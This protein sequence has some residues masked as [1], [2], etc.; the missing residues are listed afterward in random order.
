MNFDKL[1]DTLKQAFATAQSYAVRNKHQ[2][3]TNL[4]LLHGLFE[5]SNGTIIKLIQAAGGDKDIVKQETQTA[6]SKLPTVLQKWF[7]F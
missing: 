4:H 6:L 2:Y 5:D 1:G 3:L 7:G